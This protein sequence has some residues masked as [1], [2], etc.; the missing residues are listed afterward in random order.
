M[1]ATRA[2]AAAAVAIVIATEGPNVGHDCSSL[3]PNQCENRITLRME[4]GFA[5]Q[6][7]KTAEGRHPPE[8]AHAK[9]LSDRRPVSVGGAIAAITTE[10]DILEEMLDDSRD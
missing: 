9:S 5:D 8:D 1:A 4:E 10:D 7:K 2:T 3:L 6:F